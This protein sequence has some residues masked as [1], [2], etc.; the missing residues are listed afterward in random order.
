MSKYKL[1]FEDKGSFLSSHFIKALEKF[2]EGGNC[3]KNVPLEEQI[4]GILKGLS[5]AYDEAEGYERSY[6]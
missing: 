1:G 6:K 4:V 5:K 2:F 3:K